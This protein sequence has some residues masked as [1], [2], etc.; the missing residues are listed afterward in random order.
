M[1][2]T[3]VSSQT[4]RQV[5]ARYQAHVAKEAIIPRWQVAG[6]KVCCKM[7][8]LAPKQHKR[9]C[10]LSNVMAMYGSQIQKFKRKIE[11]LDPVQ[12]MELHH[13]YGEAVHD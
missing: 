13:T 9:Y 11:S 12:R 1:S 3:H 10:K 6:E 2:E 4:M 7:P 5:L 8:C